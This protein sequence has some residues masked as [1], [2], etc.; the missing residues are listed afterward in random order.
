[1]I[2]AVI[3]TYNEETK[4]GRCIDSLLGITDEI[5]VVDSFSTDNTEA[6]CRE[7]N[8]RFIQHAFEGYGQ[9]KNSG[10][11]LATYS[12]ILSIDADECLSEELKQSILEAKKELKFDGYTMNRLSN[13]CGKWIHHSGWYPDAKLRLW[14]RDKGE[15]N[16]AFAHEKIIMQHASMI[17]HLNG[18][19]LHYTA[20]TL[21]QFKEQQLGY[22]KKAAQELF[23]RRKKTNSFMI[24][25]RTAFAFLRNYFLR[26]GILD[27][28]SGW[29][30]ALITSNYTRAKYS[31]LKKMNGGDMS[32][33]D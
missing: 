10:N 14:N 24:S 31:L 13:F 3:I 15:W 22:A 33:C 11:Q 23:L 16:Y 7:K 5:L 29:Q 17:S 32:C 8:V 28:K 9:Q 2:S 27:G 12:Y 6:I 18:N 20:D 30:I 4:I 19:L 21:E 26:L 25:V 1:M